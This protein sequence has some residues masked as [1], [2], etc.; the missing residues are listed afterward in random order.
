M[1]CALSW[2]MR[3]MGLGEGRWVA[4]ETW[5]CVRAGRWT[6]RLGIF[7]FFFLWWMALDAWDC[8]EGRRIAL[9][10]CGWGRWTALEAWGWMAL[11]AWDL[12]VDGP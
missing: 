1:Q 7:F 11:E 10:A 5:D 9:E 2:E 3:R 4:L 6:L 12:G 8:G